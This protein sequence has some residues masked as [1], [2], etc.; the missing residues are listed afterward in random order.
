MMNPSNSVSAFT[1]FFLLFYLYPQKMNPPNTPTPNQKRM[2]DN[3]NLSLAL[4]LKALTTKLT[5]LDTRLKA[6]EQ[7][8]DLYKEQLQYTMACNFQRA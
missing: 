2:D 6:V 8:R 3:N 1:Y 4:A 7:E 5:Q